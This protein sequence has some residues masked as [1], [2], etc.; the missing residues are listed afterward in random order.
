MC[1]SVIDPK[2]GSLSKISVKPNYQENSSGIQEKVGASAWQ[3]GGSSWL[4]KPHYVAQGIWGIWDNEGTGKVGTTSHWTLQWLSWSCWVKDRGQEME[5]LRWKTGMY[6]VAD[7]KP[8]MSSGSGSSLSV[9]KPTRPCPRD[10]CPSRPGLLSFLLSMLHYHC[11]RSLP[12]LVLGLL[13]VEWVLLT[14]RVSFSKS[15][16]LL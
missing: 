11:G 15:C 6:K 12:S 5:Y 1:P 7:N 10:F 4:I 8:I 14:P 13:I 16:G 3:A 9:D 2:L